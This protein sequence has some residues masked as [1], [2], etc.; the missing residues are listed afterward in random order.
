MTNPN[1]D[2]LKMASKIGDQRRGVSVV[3]K[4]KE[5]TMKNLLAMFKDSNE[6]HRTAIHNKSS[7]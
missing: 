4:S 7:R 5:D 2:V 3:G 1:L 6:R